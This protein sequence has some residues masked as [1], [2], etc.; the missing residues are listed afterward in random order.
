MY[1]VY[2]V[3]VWL[4]CFEMMSFIQS[5][6]AFMIRNPNVRVS[7]FQN[8]FHDSIIESRKKVV[9]VRN[10]SLVQSDDNNQHKSCHD[11]DDD[12]NTITV[13]QSETTSKD[14]SKNSNKND[15]SKPIPKKKKNKKKNKFVIN[16]DI[17]ETGGTVISSN[18]NISTTSSSLSKSVKSNLGVPSR[19]KKPP[20]KEVQQKGKKGGDKIQRQRTANG[21]IDS[22][23]QAGIT[24]PSD[25]PVQ[26]L[27]AKRGSKEVTI[28]RYVSNRYYKIF[29]THFC[30]S[31]DTNHYSFA[32]FFN[33][34]NVNY[35][36]FCTIED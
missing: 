22:T 31:F 20:S 12:N 36:D 19:K 6:M 29:Y 28:I 7:D 10:M 15:N 4:F 18:G 30:F 9:I 2:Q 17:L 8:Q 25:Q 24:S 35:N 33:I 3:L 1:T 21:T 5:T 32:F 23:L 11:D 34:L 14:T 26:V 27:V 16:K 13:L